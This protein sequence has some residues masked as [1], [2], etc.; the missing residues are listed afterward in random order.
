MQRRRWTLQ[1][2]LS[3]APLPRARTTLRAPW[4]EP[5]WP[6]LPPLQRRRRR[7]P[8]PPSAPRPARTR[9]RL[10]RRLPTP[11][12]PGARAGRRTA[13]RALQQLLQAQRRQGLQRQR[14]RA[15]PALPA[16]SSPWQGCAWWRWSRGRRLGAAAGR[17]ASASG[18]GAGAA[19]SRAAPRRFP[20]CPR[21]SAAPRR[22]RPLRPCPARQ[23]LAA[24]PQ[25][26]Q[27]WQ[28]GGGLWRCAAGGAAGRPSA[29][30]GSAPSASRR[31]ARSSSARGSR[32][33][34]ARSSA[35]A[36]SSSSS[37]SSG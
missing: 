18:A 33:S 9:Q 19:A 27:S 21:R 15:L 23:T 7:R 6:P 11:A 28:P 1:W 32:S 31:R 13:T 30:L 35:S 17:S 20:Q 2:P 10:R 26:G 36:R 5:A 24:L 3:G 29:V 25:R 16:P 8:P 22:G 12:C 37:S 14:Q 4:S 34:S